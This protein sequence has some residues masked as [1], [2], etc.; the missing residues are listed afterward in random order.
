MVMLRLNIASD[1]KSNLKD[2]K[3]YIVLYFLVYLLPLLI[4]TGPFLP[5]L[6]VSIASL[7]FLYICIINKKTFYFKKYFFIFFLFWW[8]YLC[9][10]W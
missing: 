1:G 5:D 9:V 4:I 8:I 2:E 3:K 6:S 10:R 7:L